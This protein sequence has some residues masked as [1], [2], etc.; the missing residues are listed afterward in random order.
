[1]NYCETFMLRRTGFDSIANFPFLQQTDSQ[2][3]GSLMKLSVYRRLSKSRF[4]LF[5]LFRRVFGSVAEC[6]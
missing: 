5:E 1:M 6:D 2:L 4:T 3:S